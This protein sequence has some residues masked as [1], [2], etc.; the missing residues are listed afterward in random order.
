[1]AEPKLNEVERSKVFWLLGALKGLHEMQQKFDEDRALAMWDEGVQLERK[2]S[3]QHMQNFLAP[4][5][6]MVTLEGVRNT[7][8]P[9][10][11]YAIIPRIGVSVRLQDV[12]PPEKD[13]GR[14][15]QEVANAISV[16]EVASSSL[17]GTKVENARKHLKVIKRLYQPGS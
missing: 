14:A 8:Y 15:N 6:L 17:S 16:L 2:V 7:S 5:V 13:A 9:F 4:D 12:D 11:R 10:P 3:L 1:M